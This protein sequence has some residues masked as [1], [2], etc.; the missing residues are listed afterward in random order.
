MLKLDTRT[1]PQSWLGLLCRMLETLAR[2]SVLPT[3]SWF[4]LS[5][6][7]YVCVFIFSRVANP[8]PKNPNSISTFG[9]RNVL[10]L[11]KNSSD[12]QVSNDR[13]FTSPDPNSKSIFAKL[14]FYFFWSVQSP[15]K[16]FLFYKLVWSTLTKHRNPF[17]VVQKNDQRNFRHK[18]P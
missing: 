3:L 5:V 6:I 8:D 18:P 16:R 9:Y 1:P 11:N 14:V 13:Y 2:L 15:V 4:K 17:A 12:F 7:S 10:P